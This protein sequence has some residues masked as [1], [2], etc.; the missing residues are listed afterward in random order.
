[1]C[2]SYSGVGA[3]SKSLVAKAVLTGMERAGISAAHLWCRI[4]RSEATVNP[5]RKVKRETVRRMNRR[6]LMSGTSL[7]NLRDVPLLYTRWTKC[8]GGYATT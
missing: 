1:M 4:I 6:F 7:R 2:G 5:M 8:A 3:G